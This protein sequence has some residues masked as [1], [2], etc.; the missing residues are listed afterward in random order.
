M[1]KVTLA[2]LLLSVLIV[3]GCAR[4]ASTETDTP[5]YSKT[6]EE[7]IQRAFDLCR[8]GK[9]HEAVR[10]YVNGPQ[11]L[12]TMPSAAKEMVDRAC[13][14]YGTTAIRFEIGDKQQRG[15]G[16]LYRV[17]LSKYPKGDPQTKREMWYSDVTLIKKPQ[18]WLIALS[19]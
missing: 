18:G 3:S 2:L 11:L 9:Y 14:S 19:T 4:K 10:I 16:A 1:R 6:P 8:E 15:E 5:L 13:A 12:K 7:A 17:Y